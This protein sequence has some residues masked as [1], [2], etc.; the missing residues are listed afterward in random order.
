M[1]LTFRPALTTD[2]ERLVA[3]H[4]SAYPDERRADTRARNFT[5]NPNGALDDLWVAVDDGLVVGHSFLFALRAW[6]GGRALSVGAIASVGVAPEARGRGVASRL[7]AHL[8]DVAHA[9]RLSLTILYPFRQGF[10]ERLGYAAATPARHLRFAARALIAPSST[11]LRLRAAEARDRRSMALCW[12]AVG[13]TG[14]GMLVRSPR[15]WNAR[16]SSEDRTW[17]VVEGSEGVEGYMAWK[18][19]QPEPFLATTLVVR[20]LVARS[21]RAARALW[22]AIAAQ[23]DQVTH[24]RADVRDDDPIVYALRDPDD[25]LHA[26]AEAPHPFGVLTLGPMVRVVDVARALRE[27]GWR[28]AGTLVL[29]VA[30]DLF[31]VTAEGG[32]AH[33]VRAASRSRLRT[34]PKPDVRLSRAALSAVAF[35]GVRPFHAARLGWLE[36]RDTAALVRAERFLRLPPYFSPDRF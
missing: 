13:A 2:L 1:T 6:F 20:E 12:E 30:G 27:R 22:A 26:D 11:G 34:R 24:V 3:I 35:G 4:T 28:E 15:Q 8:H 18:V 9:R 21:D 14:T 7:I 36:A 32:R 31:S 23:R 10:Y 16:L 25:G 19:V 17:F 33:V 29:D 5:A